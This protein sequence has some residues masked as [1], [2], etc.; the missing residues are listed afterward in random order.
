MKYEKVFVPVSVDERLPDEYNSYFVL[1]NKTQMDTASR[2]DSKS[3]YFG[4]KKTFISSSHHLEDSITHW[5]EEKQ[6]VYVMSEEELYRLVSEAF[7]AGD[8]Y[9]SYLL[10][11]TVSEKPNLA[12]FLQDK[13]KATP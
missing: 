11:K 5:L 8:N 13:L 1:V 10:G 3:Y 7:H 12:K 6:N 4:K 9:A 2:C